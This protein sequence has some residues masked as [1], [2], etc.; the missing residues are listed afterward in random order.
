MEEEK[1]VLRLQ[2]NKD[3]LMRFKEV[4]KDRINTPTKCP[5]CR[6]S[7]TYFNKSSHNKTKRHQEFCGGGDGVEGVEPLINSPSIISYV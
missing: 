1:Q 3:K 6:G 7:Y 5:L 4:H 2:K